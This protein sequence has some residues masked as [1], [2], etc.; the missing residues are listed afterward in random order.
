MNRDI[1]FTSF[2]IGSCNLKNRYAMVAMGTG[3]MVN[4]DGTFNGRGTEYYVER[5]KGG[6]GL[7]ITG[8]MYVE[9]E[10]EKVLSGVMPMPTLNPNRF[11]IN[12]NELT[13]RV[14]AYDCKIFAQLTAGFGRV[15]TPHLLLSQPVSASNIE[16]FWGNGLICRELTIAEIHDIVEKCG[17]SA[18]I[19]KRAGYDGVEIH[20]VHE[21]YLL[22]QFAIS[23]FNNRTDEYGG[24]L[25]NR[26]RFACDIVKKI[27][28]KCGD[29][30]PVALRYSLK[31]FI[32]G[33][34][35]GG[36]PN[37][38]FKELGRDVEEGLMAAKILEKAG[39]DC[40]DLD[41]GSYEAWYWAHPP[42]YHEGGLNIEYGKMVKKVVDIP[43]IIAGKM[44][45]P[46]VAITALE[47]GSADIIGL[48]RPL[49]ADSDFV[50]KV[51][52][53]HIEAVRPCLGCHEGCM[54]R[55]VTSRTMSCAVNPTAGRENSWKLEPITRKKKISVI[56]AGIAGLEAARVLSQRGYN[57]RV[58]EKTD[59]MGGLLAI[60]CNESHKTDYQELLQW[61]KYEMK[62]LDVN[63]VYGKEVK[64][65][66]LQNLDSDVVI[67]ATGSKPKR[68]E[69]L[70]E[71][72]VYDAQDVIAGK[73]E[74]SDKIT[75]IGG[76]LVGCELA[77][78]LAEKNKQVRILEASKS[79]LNTSD[80][81]KMNRSMLIDLLKL[82]GVEIITDAKVKLGLNQVLEYTVGNQKHTLTS[83]TIISAIG[84]ESERKLYECISSKAKEIYAI[85]DAKCVK[86]IMYA[87][88]DSYEI[89][90]SL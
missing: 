85:G 5:A 16:S 39:Y 90:K 38:N 31:S 68:I 21:G 51:K 74:I 61:Y 34:N 35:Q 14:H 57:V 69:G 55:L 70:A 60:Y 13:E 25:E 32:K 12:S 8:T 83:D 40:L 45:N 30:Y 36:L 52:M 79:I 17:E 58:Y 81:P 47:N 59:K 53:G 26:L 42:V 56:G 66:D 37:E 24:S 78:D 84:Y 28:E 4:I 20:A 27:K 23:M 82:H 80:M 49:L 64:A 72:A 9:N 88:W 11:I 1:L 33:E 46:D 50:K 41:S 76:G 10:I 6:V 44:Q 15:M 71:G 77:L 62:R 63:I 19:C 43:V 48:G 86:N 22:D 7:I 89:C 54:H 73:V 65:D 67:V 75:I 3:G 29:N 87:I 2:Q 18:L